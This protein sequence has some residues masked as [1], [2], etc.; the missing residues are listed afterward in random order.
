MAT[1]GLVSMAQQLALTLAQRVWRADSPAL[2]VT[3]AIMMIMAALKALDALAHAVGCAKRDRPSAARGRGSHG[4]EHAFKA[5]PSLLDTHGTLLQSWTSPKDH[6]HR[7]VLRGSG[8]PAA[9]GAPHEYDG[10]LN[11]CVVLLMY[12]VLSNVIAHRQLGSIFAD[13]GVLTRYLLAHIGSYVRCCTLLTFLFITWT[14]GLQAAIT[15]G[16]RGLLRHHHVQVA[17]QVITELALFGGCFAYC[18]WS[19]SAAE[20]PFLQRLFFMAQGIVY[21][22]KQHSYLT[23]NRHLAAEVALGGPGTGTFGVLGGAAGRAAAAAPP[24]SPVGGAS[25]ETAATA[26]AAA[27]A[28]SSPSSPS[29]STCTARLSREV[30]AR[31]SREVGAEEVDEAAAAGLASGTTVPIDAAATKPPEAARTRARSPLPLPPPPAPRGSHPATRATSGG[32][33]RSSPRLRSRRTAAA[34]TAATTTTAAAA[35]TMTAAAAGAAGTPSGAEAAQPGVATSCAPAVRYPLNVTLRDFLLFT[36][37]PSLCYEP[38]F[39][40]TTHIRVGYVLEK[41]S[42]MLVLLTAQAQI[43]SAYI[44]PSLR[45]LE[46]T[47]TLDAV[48]ELL[49]PITGFCVCSFFIVFESVLN[50]SAEVTCFADRRHYDAFWNASTFTAF[51]RQ[52]NRPVHVFLLRHVYLELSRLVP[53]GAALQLTLYASIL[54]H[55]LVLWGAFRRVTFPYLGAF[56]LTQLPLAS[57]MA[58]SVIAGRRL[59]NILFWAGLTCGITL[60]VVLYARAL[61]PPARA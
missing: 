7:P 13:S 43:L 12:Y 11:L 48:S 4:S 15:R 32:G 24:L 27:A 55:E 17:L 50:I 31:L 23:V 18:Y 61:L 26:A 20:W 10:W 2:A 49:L 58:T 42:V 59:G 5:A 14:Y 44:A 22:M 1:G 25:I 51:S 19:A 16:G 35:M 3:V 21:T 46:S 52:W 8:G 6:L 38:S 56:S 37:C 34:A 28:P 39:P 30:T 40:R 29:S 47:S 57:L 9:A 53:R 60:N 36:C 54:A 33:G 45:R 41:L